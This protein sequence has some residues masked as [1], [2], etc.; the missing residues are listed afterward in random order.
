MQKFKKVPPEVQE[1]ITE[2]YLEIKS[3]METLNTSILDY[4]ELL[5]NAR[6]YVDNQELIT[7]LIWDTVRNLKELVAN[8]GF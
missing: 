6:G 4:L 1:K 8:S 2:K 7:P 5:D 3:N